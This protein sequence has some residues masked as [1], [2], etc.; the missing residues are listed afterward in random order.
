MKTAKDLLSG[1]SSDIYSVTPDQTAYEAAH[2]M[3]DKGVGGL[4]VLEGDKLV[5]IVTERD[6][7]RKT[8]E[9]SE[10]IDEIKVAEIMVTDVQCA[11][12]SDTVTDCMEVMTKG[13]FRHLPVMDGDTLKGVLSIGDLV[14]ATIKEQA[15]LISQLE[16]FIKS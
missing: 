8:H 5:G 1:K 2:M 9:R 4:V 7:L 15:E 16:Q 11:S 3:A 12:P 6:Y 14:K 13:R 10:R